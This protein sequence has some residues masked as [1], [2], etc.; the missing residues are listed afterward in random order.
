MVRRLLIVVGVCAWLVAAPLSSGYAYDYPF[1]NRYIAT[2][3]GTPE[4]FAAKLPDSVPVQQDALVM[5][6][7][8]QVPDVLW[9]LAELR[10]SYVLQEHE[11][12]LMFLIAG[13]GASYRSAKMRLMQKVF[14]QQGYSVVSL[15]S[16]THP[17]F[18]VAASC[19]GV[20]GVLGDDARDL[21]RVMDKIRNRLA[22]KAHFS[23][24]YITGYSLGAA[25]AAFVAK[26]DEQEHKFDFSRVLMIN[27]P[28]NL[29]NSVQILDAMLDD[30]IPGGL[31][32]FNQFYTEVTDA[33]TKVYKNGD[34]VEF[35][36]K[37]L[38]TAYK[39]YRAADVN[40]DRVKAVIGL[41]FRM[42]SGNMAF[43]SDVLTHAGYVVPVNAELGRNAHVT[44]YAKVL[45]RL[46]FLDYFNDILVPYFQ[47]QKPEITVADL[48]ANTSLKHID[49]Y[50]RNSDKLGMIG[51]EDDFILRPG[52]IDYL[53]QVFGERATIFPHGGHCGNMGY[54][55]NV[56]AMVNFFKAADK[57]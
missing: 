45:F 22:Q 1:A 34:N 27:P 54:P 44:E 18:I 25:Q 52:E 30:N 3:L 53:K 42:S 32:N 37:F 4:E 31:D 7:Q 10:Y 28:V 41:D 49:S 21:Y 14:Y 47:Q 20:P 15:T 55:D 56:A 23:R 51:N 29:Y 9:N 13:T 2:V 33:F 57:E 24:Y 36:D 46:T 43:V 17:N 19:S 12:P 50:L 48:I 16:P 35:N 26:L 38:Y 8:R 6:P 39:Y 40:I 5:F 11:A